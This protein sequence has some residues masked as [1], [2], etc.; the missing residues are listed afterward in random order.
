MREKTIYGDF[1]N[2]KESHEVKERLLGSV[3]EVNWLTSGAAATDLGRP[4]CQRLIGS[5]FGSF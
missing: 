3:D 2:V 1:V 4:Y 5:S